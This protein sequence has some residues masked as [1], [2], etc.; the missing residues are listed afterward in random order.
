MDERPMQKITPFLWFDG[1]AEEAANF[2]VSVFRDARIVSVT[3]AGGSGSGRPGTAMSVVF[4][5]EGQ[6]FHAF[7]GGPHFT[8]TPAISFFVSCE[9]QAELDDF[10]DKLSAGGAPQRCGWLT[11]KFGLSWQ[12]V[13]SVLGPL[14]AGPGP[15]KI[16]PG[17]AGDAE[18]D[19]APHRSLEAGLP[20]V[21][22]P[23]SPVCCGKLASP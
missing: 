17:N 6:Q 5:L 19:Q 21:A 3:R 7:N 8:F 4:E 15:R 1:K 22:E 23:R 16:R 2:Y 14:P 20:R 13:P 11:D 10:W 9:T 12:I 18:N